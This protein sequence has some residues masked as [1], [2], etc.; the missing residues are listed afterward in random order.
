MMVPIRYPDGRYDIVKT[1]QLD[2]LIVNGRIQAFRRQESWVVPGRE[3]IRGQGG[4][5]TRPDS[6]RRR[7]E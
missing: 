6:E 3:P 4:E 1:S 2:H 7:A 5:G